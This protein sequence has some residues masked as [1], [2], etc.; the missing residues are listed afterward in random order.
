MKHK[1]TDAERADRV[2]RRAQARDAKATH[3][4]VLRDWFDARRQAADERRK[5]KAAEP[6]RTPSPG[7]DYLV[8]HTDDNY[9]ARRL[10]AKQLG[11]RV[12]H[13][14]RARLAVRAGTN[15]PYVNPGRDAKRRARL[16]QELR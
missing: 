15:Q 13:R 16:R 14:G 4:Q 5:A 6:S 3:R 9:R 1:L 7:P 11:Q 2:A 12:H 10:R 8:E